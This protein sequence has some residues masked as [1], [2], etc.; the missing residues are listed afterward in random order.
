MPA[1]INT[2]R[3]ASLP[4]H[5]QPFASIGQK[6]S[7]NCTSLSAARSGQHCK[8]IDNVLAF[9]WQ[10]HSSSSLLPT[11]RHLSSFPANTSGRCD[12]P[13]PSAWP[14]GEAASTASSAALSW[15]CPLEQ[16]PY[17]RASLDFTTLSGRMQKTHGR[18]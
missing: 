13:L 8:K 14:G 18:T 9:H 15:A 11:R 4:C 5:R 17:S 12:R 3:S 1:Y 6:T 16:R 7:S 10:E 2:S